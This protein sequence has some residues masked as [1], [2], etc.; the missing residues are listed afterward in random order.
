MQ[1]ILAI[2]GERYAFM[3]SL[4]LCA[5]VVP[6]ASCVLFAAPSPLHPVTA[7]KYLLH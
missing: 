5:F 2:L 7:F 6:I 3:A 4:F 1:T